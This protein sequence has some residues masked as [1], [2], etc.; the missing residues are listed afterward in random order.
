MTG[1]TLPPARALV[2]APFRIFFLLA[3]LQAAVAVPLWLGALAHGWAIAP[4][5]GGRDW[6][7]HEMLFGYLG[8]VI[9]GFLFTAIPNWTGR[10]PLAGR[11]L[12]ALA[13]LWLAGRLA[14]LL[15]PWPWLVAAVAPAFLVVVAALVWREVM[16]GRNWR[17]AP[18]C[19][20]VS[21][22]A[23]A[24]IAVHVPGL[25]EVAVRLALATVALLV[26]LIGGRVVPSFSRNWLAGRGAVRLPVPFGMV[27]KLVLALSAL[28]LAAWV[29]APEA[30]VAG[31]LLLGAGL[32]N[33][34][35]LVRW[36]GWATVREPLLLILHAGYLWL[37]VALALLGGAALWPAAVGATE[38]LHALTAGAFGTMTLAVM[39]RA[40]LGHSGRPLTA[41]PATIAIYLLVTAGALLRVAAPVLPGGYLLVLAVSGILWSAAF[42]LFVVAYGP[43]LLGRPATPPQ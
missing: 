36:R 10:L 16:A 2:A 23:A 9:A 14:A 28:A 27:D 12:A 40:S 18:P 11:G 43:L 5:L 1:A 3:A 7:V 35:R 19:V 39:T 31:L 15:S 37:A 32:A 17:N 13:L 42:A 21:L 24:G 33:V 22:L 38:A 26:V 25:A 34:V 20:L 6:H 29:A 30:M 8:A 4:A 41:G